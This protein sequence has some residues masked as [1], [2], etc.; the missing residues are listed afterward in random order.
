MD[1]EV[2][3]E[4]W[5]SFAIS[6]GLRQRI[7]SP[8]MASR[9][10]WEQMRHLRAWRAKSGGSFA[11]GVKTPAKEEAVTPELKLRPPEDESSGVETPEEGA[12]VTSELKLRPPEEG[13][14]EEGASERGSEE[15]AKSAEASFGSASIAGCSAASLMHSSGSGQASCAAL[16][17][18]KAANSSA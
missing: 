7:K 5:W 13:G 18:W 4:I 16:A 10:G 15:R 2:R 6:S 1:A 17:A 12:A 14:A 11:S 8:S 9:S 3:S